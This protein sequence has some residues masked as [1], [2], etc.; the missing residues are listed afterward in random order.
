MPGH[1]HKH[2][3]HAGARDHELQDRLEDAIARLDQ[4]DRVRIDR[5]IEHVHAS[6]EDE[7]DADADA[8][9]RRGWEEPTY[10]WSQA[11]LSKHNSKANRYSDIAS[12]DHAL[13]SGPYLNAA[14]IP[15]LPLGADSG[16]P[17][18]GPSRQCYV[19]SQAPLPHTFPTFFAHLVAQR[20][21]VLVMLTP[22]QERGRR[23]ADAYWPSPAFQ[24]SAAQNGQHAES[25]AGGEHRSFFSRLHPGSHAKY[26]RDGAGSNPEGSR[27]SQPLVLDSSGWAVE[28]LE[29]VE[30]H[31]SPSHASTAPTRQSEPSSLAQQ[32][33]PEGT[34]RRLPHGTLLHLRR[35]RIH[36]G[37]SPPEHS[38][39]QNGSPASPSSSSQPQP[40]GRTG[41]H[42]VV[43]L[44]LSS[45]ADFGADSLETLECLLDWI[46]HVQYHG[47]QVAAVPP[48]IW[49]HCSA[50]VGRSGTV[51]A[52]HM[53]RHTPTPPSSLSATLPSRTIPEARIREF[54][55]P[56]LG[57]NSQEATEDEGARSDR[58]ITVAVAVVAH[59]RHFRPSMVQTPV[60]L[61]MVYDVALASSSLDPSST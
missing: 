26:G 31:A 35:L 48:P 44:H 11:R 46:D 24:Q 7:S 30:L 23:K 40:G 58:A 52:A 9:E 8:Q 36:I 57:E 5:W 28:T 42:D 61:G 32:S 29:E 59:M 54:L 53:L 50:G 19:A 25:S 16:T 43:Q 6:Y 15:P 47:Q 4:V 22:L 51:I 2:G 10:S 33:S 18:A 1:S 17:V 27:G 21:R 34:S 12:W 14:L 13:L 60:Q 56:H 55:L 38:S 45:W 20:V 41:T 37:S 3:K 49:V 39:H